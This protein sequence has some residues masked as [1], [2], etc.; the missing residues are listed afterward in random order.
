MLQQKPVV[1][2]SNFW[3]SQK[4][5]KLSFSRKEGYSKERFSTSEEM[6]VTVHNLI[7]V[8]YKVQ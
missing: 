2:E 6:W 4:E 3:V 1:R 5:K 7:D 8:G